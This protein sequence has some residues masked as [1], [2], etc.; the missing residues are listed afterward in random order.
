LDGTTARLADHWED[1]VLISTTI[2]AAMLAVHQP[3]ELNALA[4][5]LQGSAP[6]FAF[7]TA[8]RVL[9]LLVVVLRF[10]SSE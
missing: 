6:Y 1:E 9:D 8:W 3:H 4:I 2:F 10:A 7:G 5:R